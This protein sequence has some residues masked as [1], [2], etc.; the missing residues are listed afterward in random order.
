MD[1][2]VDKTGLA[3]LRE[4]H[5]SF[6]V[7]IWGTGFLMQGWASMVPTWGINGSLLADHWS[8]EPKTLYGEFSM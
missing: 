8:D 4:S 5:R 6:D 7:I 2:P 3:Q 1:H